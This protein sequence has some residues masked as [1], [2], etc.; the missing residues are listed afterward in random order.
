MP[1]KQKPKRDIAAEITARMIK[2][3]EAGTPPWK[4]PWTKGGAAFPLRHTGERYSGVNI[5]ALWDEA[6]TQGYENPRW[7]TFNQALALG[8][9]VRKGQKSTGVIYY[10]TS[11][12]TVENHVGEKEDV[13]RSFLKHF[14]VFNVE[15]ID[16][17]PEDY[18]SFDGAALQRTPPASALQ[19]FFEAAGPII[20]H[21]GGRAYYRPSSD[22]IQMPRFGAFDTAHQYYAT[23]A[24]ECIHWTGAEHRLNRF[25]KLRDEQNTAFEELIAEIGAAMLGAHLGLPPDHIDSHAAYVQSWLKAL[26]NDTR[27]I[28]KAAAAAQSACDLVLEKA[29]EGGF[30]LAALSSDP[31]TS[32]QPA[33]GAICAAAA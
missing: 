5:L 31:V 15:Q 13:A 10:G 28:F 14:N 25:E 4:R 2:A 30:D 16:G 22:H 17:L 26:K 32:N 9:G 29:G 7:M 19:A 1:R 21:G 24:H 23:L 20:R 8:G 27:M 11:V 12:K 18:Y 33:S 3:I 6:D